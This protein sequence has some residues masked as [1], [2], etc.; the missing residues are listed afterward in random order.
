MK[1]SSSLSANDE[2]FRKIISPPSDILPKV[3]RRSVSRGY[4]EEIERHY[5]DFNG[6]TTNPLAIKRVNSTK[7]ANYEQLIIKENSS[8]CKGITEKND[9]NKFQRS[10][11]S[12]VIE[13]SN[14]IKE[15]N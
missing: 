12:P 8:N 1:L 14:L 9:E 3:G 6:E 5:P 4:L 7:I 15:A 10:H 2:D 13:L 11:T